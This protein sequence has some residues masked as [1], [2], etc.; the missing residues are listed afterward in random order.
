MGLRTFLLFFKIYSSEIFN[1]ISAICITY[2]LKATPFQ[3]QGETVGCYD[4]GLPLYK[5]PVSRL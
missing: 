4:V 1:L 3:V 5:T 2:N